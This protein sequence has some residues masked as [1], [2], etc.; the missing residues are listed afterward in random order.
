VAMET[1]SPMPEMIA[2][3]LQTTTSTR[4]KLVNTLRV[5]LPKNTVNLRALA[6]KVSEQYVEILTDKG[7]KR[8]FK[9]KL[10]AKDAY[11]LLA[12]RYE[13]IGRFTEALGARQKALEF[14]RELS[15][16]NDFSSRNRLA[17]VYLPLS[18]IYAKTCHF[19]E[20]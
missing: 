14:A 17:Q 13:S 8:N 3:V 16:S 9:V 1:G 2:S 18:V 19:S 10:N 15:Q 7:N 5:K 6:V 12:S 4:Q 11:D 20:A